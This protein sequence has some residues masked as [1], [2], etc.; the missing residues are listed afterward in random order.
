MAAQTLI[1][2]FIV[3]YIGSIPP[4]TINISVMQLA[5]RKKHQAA[6]FFALAAAIVELIYAGITV[7]FQILLTSNNSISDYLRIITSIALIGWGCGNIFSK[8]V[9]RS[10]KVDTKLTGLHG[11]LRGMMISLFNPMT[12]PFWLITTTYL[13]KEG[14]IEITSVG[15]WMYLTGLSTGT[16]CF[17]LTVD[18][19]GKKFTKISDNPFLVHKLPGFILLGMGIYFLVKGMI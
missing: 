17:L 5:I 19:L 6:I 15:F 3:S 16:F 4:G 2:A 9:A 18:T 10:I 14:L 7:Q 8:S 1:L 13:E 12:I 11:F